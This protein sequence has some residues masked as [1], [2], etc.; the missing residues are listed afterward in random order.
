MKHCVYHTCRASV[1]D[2]ISV[3]FHGGVLAQCSVTMIALN[4]DF[5]KFGSPA[6]H[7]LSLFLCYF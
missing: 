7:K 5:I 3:V 4:H 2:F 1:Q 6:C